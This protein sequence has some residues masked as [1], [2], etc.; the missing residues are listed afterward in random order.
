MSIGLGFVIQRLSN[1]GSVPSGWPGSLAQLGHHC[2]SLSINFR[3]SFI[4]IVWVNWVHTV[5]TLAINCQLGHW[6]IRLG[7]FPSG[8]CQSLACPSVWSIGPSTSVSHT[9]GS[10]NW[11]WVTGSMSN[12]VI[13]YHTTITSVIVR[14]QLINN[15][16]STGSPITNNWVNNNTM[17]NTNNWSLACQSLGWKVIR[18]STGSI[19]VSHQ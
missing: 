14:H 1:T 5:H 3:P 10:V 13:Q 15:V 18:Q 8:H 11:V 6:V 4:N 9:T 12:T 17:A 2:P 7:Q 16:Q 19:N